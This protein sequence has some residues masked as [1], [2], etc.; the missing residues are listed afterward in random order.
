MEP[1]SRMGTLL[2]VGAVEQFIHTLLW[3][4]GMRA[5]LREDHQRWQRGA[6]ADGRKVLRQE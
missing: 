2:E 3:C 4:S 1:D 6:T 5:S